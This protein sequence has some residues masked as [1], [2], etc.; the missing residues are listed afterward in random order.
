VMYT[1]N[2]MGLSGA[3]AGHMRVAT[4][5]H[6]GPDEPQVWAEDRS[7]FCVTLGSRRTMVRHKAL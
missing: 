4:R 6:A 5:A 1:S 2:N 7:G 3:T